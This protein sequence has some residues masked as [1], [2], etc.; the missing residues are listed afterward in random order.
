[1]TQKLV[2]LVLIFKK[3]RTTDPN[4]QKNNGQIRSKYANLVIKKNK[5]INNGQIRSKY[6]NLVIKKN[7]PMNNRQIRS[8][9]ANLVI[10]KNK[11]GLLPKIWYLESECPLL[12]GLF[13]NF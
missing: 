3:N 6:A 5:P 9:Y 10:K 2:S 7:K 4:F 11:K 13:S 1:M 8:K 12:G